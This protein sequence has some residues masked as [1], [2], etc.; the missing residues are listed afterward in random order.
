MDLFLGTN[1]DNLNDAVAKRIIGSG[2]NAWPH[3]HKDR[4]SH[5]E[6]HYRSKLTNEHVIRIRGDSRR[7]RE[8]AVEFGISEALVSMVRNRKR[9]RHIS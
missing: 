5:G 2:V 3:L 8:I 6:S 4:I 1:T 9:W 7:L